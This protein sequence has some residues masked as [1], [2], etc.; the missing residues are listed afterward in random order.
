MNLYGMT[1]TV[2]LK[3]ENL[4]IHCIT[5]FLKIT[6]MEFFTKNTAPRS[7]CIM[8]TTKL[9][10]IGLELSDSFESMEIACK[11]YIK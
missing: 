1:G 6:S 7:N 4:L 5:Y 3:K 9:K 2:L 8:N 11:N 10:N